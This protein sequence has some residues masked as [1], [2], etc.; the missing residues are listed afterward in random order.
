MPVDCSSKDVLVFSPQQLAW[1]SG[2][3]AVSSKWVGGRSASNQLHEIS[4]EAI[5]RAELAGAICFRLRLVILAGTLQQ[6]RAAHRALGCGCARVRRLWSGPSGACCAVVRAGRRPV[7]PEGQVVPASGKAVLLV[8][9]WESN[10]F[11][12]LLISE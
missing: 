3:A 9:D 10:A 6:R 7:G 1:P 11:G 2:L 4:I 8:Q 5:F 12:L